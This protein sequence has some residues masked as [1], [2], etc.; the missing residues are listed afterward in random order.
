M[1]KESRSTLILTYSPVSRVIIPTPGQEYVKYINF[2]AK[3][4]NLNL[5]IANWGPWFINHLLSMVWRM[6]LL[7]QRLQSSSRLIRPRI[8]RIMLPSATNSQ[9]ML[10][11]YERKFFLGYIGDP[12][13]FVPPCA[14]EATGL[15]WRH[16]VFSSVISKS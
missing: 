12:I 15:N 7:L 3:R 10:S 11:V 4:I 8:K 13:Y 1:S 6:D 14:L 9:N 16:F 5:C 2:V